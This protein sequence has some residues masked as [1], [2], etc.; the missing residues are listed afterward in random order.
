[1]TKTEAQAIREK[2]EKKGTKGTSRA[3]AEQALRT[4][5]GKDVAVAVWLANYYPRKS[6]FFT[7]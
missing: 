1:M 7:R 4:L 3:I 2:V 5:F 6:D